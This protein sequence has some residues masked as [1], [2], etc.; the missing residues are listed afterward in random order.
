MNMKTI[1]I[2]GVAVVALAVP[3]IAQM[4]R[5]DRPAQTR[6]Q[7]EAKVRNHFA[8]ID[9]NKDGY[10]TAE[11]VSAMRGVAMDKRFERMDSDRNGA[12]SRTEFDAA[13]AGRAG[14]HHGMKM[15]RGGAQIMMMA[16]ADKDGR[17]A[18]TEAVNGALMLFDRADTDRDG[19]LT[20]EERRTARQAMR[21]LWR[22]RAGG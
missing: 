2:G 7:A 19:T 9:A 12:I 14:G 13:H 18:V 5:P 21:E 8:R 17:V 6:A 15:G 20:A 10:V 16:D 4:T 3:A 1:I 22:A 11:D